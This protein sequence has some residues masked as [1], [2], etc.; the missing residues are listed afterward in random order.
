MQ[1]FQKIKSFVIYDTY[2][3][4]ASAN[5]IICLISGIFLAI[6]Y[7]VNNPYDSISLMLIA[8][9]AAVLFRNFHYWSAQLFLVFS[10][11]HLWD[12]LKDKSEKQLSKGIWFRLTT[13]ISIILLVMI[14]GFILKGD[15]DSEQ[16]RRIISNLFE[17]IPLVGKLISYGLFGEENT[18]QLTYIHH[19]ATTSIFLVIIIFEHAKTLW[20]KTSTFLISLSIAILLSFLLNAPLHDNLNPVIKGPWYFIGLQEILHWLSDP[21]IIVWAFPLLFVIIYFMRSMKDQP[22]NI[23]KKILLFLFWIYLILTIVG[24]FF[25]GENWEW[26]A[27]SWMKKPLL[28]VIPK[29][30][31]YKEEERPVCFAMI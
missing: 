19:I 18:Y 21:S 10:F 9:P 22:A 14:T 11:L 7:D 12:H 13:S 25:R 24:F 15:A 26:R 1:L 28:L 31:K 4:I 6:P 3:A 2:G 30:L 5:F 16:A 8:N 20:V 29:S 23:F 27:D 17:R